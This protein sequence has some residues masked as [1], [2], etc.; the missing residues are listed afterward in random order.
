MIG[1]FQEFREGCESIEEWYSVLREDER[2]ST[3][4]TKWDRW[5]HALSQELDEMFTIPFNETEINYINSPILDDLATVLNDFEVNLTKKHHIFC[6][7]C[8][9]GYLITAQWLLPHI[10]IYIDLSEKDFMYFRIACENGHL[11][12]AKWLHELYPIRGYEINHGCTLSYICRKGAL[13]VA[14]WIH[15]T[16][17]ESDFE[18]CANLPFTWACEQGHLELAQWLH[19]FCYIRDD[20]Y[21]DAYIG[22]ICSQKLAVIQWLKTVHNESDNYLFR[23]ACFQYPETAKW[24][25]E[26]LTVTNYIHPFLL[27]LMI[28]KNLGVASFIYNSFPEQ[29]VGQDFS[30][31]FFDL[32]RDGRFEDARWLR[33]LGHCDQLDNQSYNQVIQDAYDNRHYSL[34]AWLIAT[35]P[36]KYKL[37]L[38]IVA[39]GVALLLPTNTRASKLNSS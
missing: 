25:S 36:Q 31:Y 11:D 2:L 22:A 21:L 9:R 19:S 3:L 1:I 8:K 28:D 23:L 14:E 16:F 7:L 6:G 38:P 18:Q 30:D 37:L 39:I 12:F 4:L 29:F 20:Q 10:W 15:E 27:A 13:N 17:P 32:C 33:N 34:F 5:L 26:N 35:H 24:V